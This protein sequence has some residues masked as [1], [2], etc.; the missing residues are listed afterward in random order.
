VKRSRGASA[1]TEVSGAPLK[2]SPAGDGPGLDRARHAAALDQGLRIGRRLGAPL[3]PLGVVVGGLGRLGGDQIAHRHVDDVARAVEAQDDVLPGVVDREI[4]DVAVPG[5][6]LDHAPET[7]IDQEQPPARRDQR[8]DAARR[9]EADQIGVGEGEPVLHDR[10]VQPDHH[11][12]LRAVGVRRRRRHVE[13]HRRGA[14]VEEDRAAEDR[15]RADGAGRPPLGGRLAQGDAVARADQP[16]VGRHRQH[17]LGVA[18]HRRALE[19]AVAGDEHARRRGGPQRAAAERDADQPALA[20]QSPQRV[21]IAD[22]LAGEGDPPQRRHDAA[23]GDPHLSADHREVLDRGRGD[24]D[25][26][27]G[28][29]HVD[30]LEAG[31][32]ADDDEVRL[33][34]EAEARPH[35]PHEH[36]PVRSRDVDEVRTR[37]AAARRR[38]SWDPDGARELVIAAGAAGGDQREL[39]VASELLGRIA[40]V[41]GAVTIA[42]QAFASAIDAWVELGEPELAWLA[43]A[44]QRALPIRP[45]TSEREALDAELSLLEPA[46]PGQNPLVARALVELRRAVA[47]R[48]GPGRVEAAFGLDPA[49]MA[50]LFAAVAS[51]LDEHLGPLRTAAEWTPRLAPTLIEPP[52]AAAASLVAA[53]LVSETPVLVPSPALI[54]VL[55]GRARMASPPGVELTRHDGPLAPVPRVAELAAALGRRG[56]GVVHGGSPGARAAAAAAVARRLGFGLAVAAPAGRE[57]AAL[58]EAAVEA[59]LFDCLIAIDLDAW[60]DAGVDVAAAVAAGALAPCE[61]GL[62][63]AAADPPLPASRRAFTLGTRPAEVSSPR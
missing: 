23:L 39:A 38:A 27:R 63:L 42:D 8:G 13:Q 12:L 28:P 6:L 3:G 24:L 1:A 5:V 57:V 40:A 50:L 29:G 56:V 54:G 22:R 47:P 45:F 41:T 30:D 21:A 37:L 59:R 51:L 36:N 35:R 4:D 9:G 14:S 2:N 58:R 53:G 11:E 16:A 43:A 17:Q 18:D 7:Q 55:L 61:P 26:R 44:M 20:G 60:R 46:A 19:P 48:R 49:E 10:L 31:G 62:V 34:R 25:G 52:G 15:A 33:G 32:R